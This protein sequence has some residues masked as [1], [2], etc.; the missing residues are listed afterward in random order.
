LVFCLCSS[1]FALGNN[2]VFAYYVAPSNIWNSFNFSV[3]TSLAY[4]GIYVNGSGYITSY[5]GWPNGDMIR[6]AHSSGAQVVVV[7]NGDWQG[8][9][10][11]RQAAKTMAQEVTNAVVN[12]GADG[13]NV[14]F[15][16]IPAN[17]KDDFSYA[18]SV[19]ADSLHGYQKAL[20]LA[21][22]VTY[23]GW[24]KGYD[25]PYL[26][27]VTDGL[28]Y[29]AYDMNWGSDIA[30]A[31]APLPAI[32][33]DLKLSLSS[34]VPANKMI[35]GVPWYGYEYPCTTTT[36]GTECRTNHPW[37]MPS[38]SYTTM[39]ARGDKYGLKWDSKSSSPY[40]EYLDSEGV[41]VQGWFDDAR[42]LALK[43][44]MA[45]GLNLNGVGM[46]DANDGDNLMWNTI[47]ANF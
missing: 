33:T 32:E 9:L 4:D 19:L 20:T 41:R 18:M 31:N 39:I 6:R 42:S 29:M 34:N 28:F 36:F 45:K 5:N 12:A 25:Y 22:S 23:D 47:A 3:L 26:A 44:Q 37:P 30:N 13:A 10:P 11:Q 24:S 14:D 38:Y 27:Q 35:L 1:T 2:K 40:Y 8:I 15:E 46:W 43:Y 21:V 16:G 17:L 7:V